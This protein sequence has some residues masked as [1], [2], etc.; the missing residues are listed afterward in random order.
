MAGGKKGKAGKA[1][2]QAKI[3]SKKINKFSVSPVAKAK[4]PA[5]TQPRVEAALPAVTSEPADEQINDDY[6]ARA[7]ADPTF[8]R[9]RKQEWLRWRKLATSKE[10]VWETFQLKFQLREFLE[11][12]PNQIREFFRPSFGV[13]PYNLSAVTRRISDLRDEKLKALL[14]RYTKYVLRYGVGLTLARTPPYFRTRGLGFWGNKFDVAIRNGQLEPIGGLPPW[15]EEG[16][17]PLPTRL[18]KQGASPLPNRIKPGDVLVTGTPLSDGFESDELP[19]PAGL[20]SLLKEGWAK[21]VLIEDKDKVSILRQL[22]D[23]AY[24]PD[25]VT[26][27]EYN[28]TFRHKFYLVGENVP[29]QKVWSQLRRVAAD[30][31][32]QTGGGD[33]RGRSS[34]KLWRLSARL[35]LIVRSDRSLQEKGQVLMDMQDREKLRDKKV[36]KAQTTNRNFSNQSDLS[37]LKQRLKESSV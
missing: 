1:S 15:G 11:D 31:Q 10:F 7:A 4:P 3:P 29:L 37:Q 36:P 23:F 35:N 34:T 12:N 17:R 28:S 25:Q 14:I 32:R 33:Q 9:I 24:S 18:K 19:V 27:I 21:Y 30:S 26:V 5:V 20:Q 22:T 13:T 8:P 6:K 16:A 2:K